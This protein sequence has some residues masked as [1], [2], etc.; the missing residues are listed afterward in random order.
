VNKSFFH[1][2]QSWPRHLAHAAFWVFIF[3]TIGFAT[4]WVDIPDHDDEWMLSI[5][6]VLSAISLLVPTML[7]MRLRLERLTGSLEIIIV[8][9]QLASWLGAFG[10]YRDGFGYD[11][12][13][14]V[15]S[16][17]LLTIGTVW[18]LRAA[19]LARRAGTLLLSSAALVLVFVLVNELY[20]WG[21]DTFFSTAL[22]GEAGESDDTWRD[23]AANLVGITIGIVIG[24]RQ[25]FY[26][27]LHQVEDKQSAV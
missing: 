1:F 21:S 19:G 22:Y 24:N 3:L 6:A 26:A 23:M 7:A 18:T 15:F 14:H 8:L 2:Q 20:E 25:R 12:F 17:V 9:S 4:N 16:S 27:M 5:L 11:T 10:W 13:V